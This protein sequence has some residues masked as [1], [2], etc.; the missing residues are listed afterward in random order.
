MQIIRS[1]DE[2]VE[3]INFVKKEGKSIGFVPT[4]GFLHEGHKSLIDEARKKNQIVVV[5]AFINPTQFGPNEDFENYPRDEK[6]DALLCE[7]AGCDYMFLPKPED[8]YRDG[9]NTYVNVF[10]I[11]E[12]LCGATRPIHFRG[13]CTVV[14][15]LFNIV[16]PNNAYFGQK[17]AQQLVVIKRMVSDLNL[18]V[19]IV[20]CPIIRE[21]DGLALSSRNTYLSEDERQQALVLSKA[22]KRAKELVENGQEDVFTI[23]EEMI[24][25]INV[26][27]DSLIDYIE[28]VDNYNLKPIEKV[29]GEVLVA[30]AVKIG[31]TRLIDNMVVNK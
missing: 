23:K 5:S 28:F 22:L 15:K 21:A 8:M 1:V 3:K 19:K 20:G 16:K 11:T 13:V 12:G 7:K 30:M 14:L 26:A 31:K 2:M 17:D 24:K 27:N 29:R 6:K 4:M 9:Y 25:I 18:E 10:G